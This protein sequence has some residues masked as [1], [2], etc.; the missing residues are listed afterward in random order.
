[1]R[2]V[3]FF[4]RKKEHFFRFERVGK[5]FSP[6]ISLLLVGFFIKKK[7]DKSSILTFTGKII[8][9]YHFINKNQVKR[10]CF[11]IPSAIKKRT[12]DWLS[13]LFSAKNGRKHKTCPI[14][15]PKKQ[16]TD[17]IPRGILEMTLLSD[18][19]SGENIFF[20]DS[21]IPDKKFRKSKN[22]T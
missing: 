21:K 22:L 15:D 16:F 20:R 17:F 7:L 6:I 9:P 14:R 1:M 10:K 13:G 2:I 8:H 3:I 5:V 4:R 19:S 18:T 11:Q 12:G